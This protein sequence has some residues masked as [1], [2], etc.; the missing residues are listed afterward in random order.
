MTARHRPA[1]R[2]DD[3]HEQL[4]DE[5]HQLV[6]MWARRLLQVPPAQPPYSVHDAQTPEQRRAAWL[7]LLA[8]CEQIRDELDDWSKLAA[9]TAAAAGADYGD[10]GDAVGMTRQG[11]RRR[12]PGLAG[13]A[14]TARA[15]GKANDVD[16]HPRKAVT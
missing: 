5:V 11:A 2:S 9:R 4:V 14:K 10:L 1:V 7:A 3:Q 6:W 16:S 15:D 8:A 12:W 13:L